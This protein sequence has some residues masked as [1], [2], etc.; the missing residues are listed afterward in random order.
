LKAMPA[1]PG[2]L[3][4]I[5]TARG[6]QVFVDYAHTDDALEKVLGT[7]RELTRRRLIAVFG[8][9]GNRDM[10]KREPMGRVVD[11]LA[12]Y[13]I[14]TSD[15]PRKEDPNAIM[16]QIRRGFQKPGQHELIEDRAAAIRRAI[17][18][19]GEGDVVLVAGKG[20]ETFQEFAATSVP[21]DDRAV[22]RK[23]LE[24]R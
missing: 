6:F 12:D 21:F 3:E 19:A 10:T 17:A 4:E 7:L 13:A 24:Q 18:L 20:H 22:V 2:R 16:E 11:A 15:N 14:I 8:C 23:E 9:G 1:V 5:P